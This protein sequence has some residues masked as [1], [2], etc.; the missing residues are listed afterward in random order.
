[1]CSYYFIKNQSSPPR[2]V[3]NQLDV[4]TETIIFS[5]EQYHWARTTSCCP[6]C[7][8]YRRVYTE[9]LPSLD[10]VLA[11]FCYSSINQWSW[12]AKGVERSSREVWTVIILGLATRSRG[13]I[14]LRMCYALPTLVAGWLQEISVP[15]QE[16]L[17]P[18]VVLLLQ[19]RSSQKVHYYTCKINFLFYFYYPIQI[20]RWF[21]VLPWQR[22]GFCAS[23]NYV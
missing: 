14:F 13:C 9:S 2:F 1:M 11:C 22:T 3:W 7:L 4:S 10:V 18:I 15:G 12:K 20:T 23:Y 6:G 5:S 21:S 19:P 16:L 8:L 17:L